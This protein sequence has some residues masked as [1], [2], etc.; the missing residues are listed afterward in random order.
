MF[1]EDEDKSVNAIMT[2]SDMEAQMVSVA[3]PGL[4]YDSGWDRKGMKMR[5]RV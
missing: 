5:I 4:E 1:V 3:R 2:R